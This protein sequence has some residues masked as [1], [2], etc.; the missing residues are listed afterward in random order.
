MRQRNFSLLLKSLS[1]TPSVA[2]LDM[3]AAVVDRFQDGKVVS[4]PFAPSLS[5]LPAVE[6]LEKAFVAKALQQAAGNKAKA[7]RLLE[8][9]ERAVW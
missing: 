1:F 2:Y 8:I 3:H 9:S 6:R 7:A 4:I 5:L